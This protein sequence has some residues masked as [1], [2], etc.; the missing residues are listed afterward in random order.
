MSTTEQPDSP[1][2]EAG[3]AGA[4]SQKAAPPVPIKAGIPQ[5]APPIPVAKGSQKAAPPV[6]VKVPANAKT[7]SKVVARTKTQDSGARRKPRFSRKQVIIGLIAVFLIFDVGLFS[8]LFV[9]GKLNLRGVLPNADTAE[10]VRGQLSN[11]QWIARIGYDDTT[12]TFAN[13]TE[14]TP[15][16]ADLTIVNTSSLKPIENDLF[17]GGAGPD[18]ADLLYDEVIVGRIIK[19]NSDWVSYLNEGKDAVFSS[20]QPGSPAQTKLT[21]LGAGS[22]VAYHQLAIGEIRHSGRNYYLITKATYTLSTEGK[23][24]IHEDVFVYKL[25]AQGNTLVVVDFEQ[26]S[27][28]NPEA[29]TPQT[30]PDETPAVTETDTTGVEGEGDVAPEGEQD[31]TEPEGEDNAGEGEGAAEGAAEEPDTSQ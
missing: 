13:I 4:D 28:Q 7:K 15:N 6:P 14:L 11:N 20:L 30:V 24:D 2:N 31:A 16:H 26:F 21:E 9:S 3:R 8:W 27:L 23:L 1:A 22:R 19:L 12:L 10:L 18:G 17:K 29:Q 25:T 5:A